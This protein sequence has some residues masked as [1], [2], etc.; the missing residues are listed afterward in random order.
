MERV[1]RRETD[2]ATHNTAIERF[3]RELVD[4]L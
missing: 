3:V 2:F 4:I 1:K